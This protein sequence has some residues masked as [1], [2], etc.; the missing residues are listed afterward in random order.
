M[1]TFFEEHRA[2]VEAGRMEDA[3]RLSGEK[4]AESEAALNAASKAGAD[5]KEL[6]H[7]ALMLFNVGQ[8]HLADLHYAG[9]LRDEA[10]TAL[11]IAATII[12]ARVNP[13]TVADR[14]VDWLQMATMRLGDAL[15]ESGDERL[16]SDFARML[17]LA[18][19]TAD[20]YAA[21]FDLDAQTL[22]VNTALK[23]YL[24]SAGMDNTD[25]DGHP[26][27]PQTAIDI[28]LNTLN[29]MAVA[30]WIQPV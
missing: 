9:M 16:M 27:V 11:M 8:A 14:Y 20:D 1:S 18:V 30:G 28:L 2:L 5:G 25:Y 6:A 4:L 21:R 19:V 26:I 3:M 15:Q 13:E 29:T 17:K 7:K 23:N 12:I 22:S 10:A 24:A